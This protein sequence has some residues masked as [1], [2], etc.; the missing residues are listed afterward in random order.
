MIN[1]IDPRH[2][3]RL[4]ALQVLF[5]ADI[6]ERP[7]GDLVADYAN[8]MIPADDVRAVGYM[9]MQAV[10]NDDVFWSESPFPVLNDLNLVP[11]AET[12]QLLRVLIDGVLN[13]QAVIDE[14]IATYAPEWPLDQ[15]AVIERNVL[16]IALFEIFYS[17]AI[18]TSVAISEAV[19]IVKLYGADNASSFVNGVLGKIADNQDVIEKEL[20][21]LDLDVDTA[22]DEDSDSEVTAGQN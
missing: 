11:T 2:L 17:S 14:T 4:L 13:Y 6:A 21:Q 7:A 19:R 20:N 8:I 16:R 1:P 18:P 9:A 10:Y 22:S 3:A 5:E 15:M 12:Y